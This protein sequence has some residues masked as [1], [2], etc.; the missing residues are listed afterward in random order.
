METRQDALIDMGEHSDPVEVARVLV[1][2]DLPQLDRPLDYSVPEGLSADAQP[3]RLVRVRLAGRKTNGWIVSRDRVAPGGRTLQPLLSVVSDVQVVT[4][5]VLSLARSLADRN[6]STASQVLSLAV[7]AR[8]AAT[9]RAVLAEPDPEALP[10]ETPDPATWTDHPGGAAL[11]GHLSRG[12]SPRAVWTALPTTRD[13]QLVALVRAVRASGRAVLVIAP[14]NAQVDDLR[15]ILAADLG[16]EQV[17]SVSA[18]D[19][20]AQRYRVHLEGLLGRVHV[21]VGTRSAVWC[22][23]RDLSLLVVWD[24]GDDRLVEQRAPHLGAL[25]VAVARAHLEGAGLVAGAFSR[26]TKAQALVQAHW[27]ASLLP[28]RGAL[29]A[30]TPRVW[31]PDDF[32]REREGAAS[33]A[34]LPPSAQRLVRRQLAAGPVLVQVPLSGYV[35]VVC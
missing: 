30:S 11:L 16:T 35:P 18:E 13:A 17:V 1:D 24:D 32:D 23:V 14:T 28:E 27:A 12:E 20:P 34:H 10:V 19:T 31:V 6:V 33:A 4:P 21:V 26:S 15:S 22:P 7:P 5:T 29:R 3:G 2:V 8:H 25:D 9:E